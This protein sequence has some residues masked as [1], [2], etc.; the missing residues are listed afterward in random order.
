MTDPLFHPF[1]SSLEGISV[2]KAFTYPFF[3]TPHALVELASK[4][5]QNHLEANDLRHNFGLGNHEDLVE[6]GKMFGV[7]VVRNQD[8]HLGWLAA[9]SGKLHEEVEGYFVPPICDIHAAQ[10]FYKKGENELNAMSA[11]IQAKENNPERLK[12]I[13]KVN[14]RLADIKEHLRKGRADLKE[15]KKARQKY[16]ETVAKVMSESDFEK[17]KDRLAQESIQG[18]VAFKHRSKAWIEEQ[19]K[20]EATL[21]EYAREIE[22][23]KE[24][25]KAK[26]NQLQREIFD[27]YVFLNASGEEKVLSQCF[28]DFDLRHPPS[29]SG[30]CAAPKLLQYAYQKGL[31]PVCMG[32]FW[33]GSA[34]VK[35][36]RKHKYFY[37]S[38]ASRCRPIL[39]HMLQGLN[40]E[41][42][43]LLTFGKDKPMPVVY[44]DDDLVVVNKPAGLLSVPGVDI[45]DSALVRVK[46]MYPE[47][48]GAILLHRLDMSTSGLLMFTLNPKANKRMQ[49]Q[50]IKRQVNKTYIADVVGTLEAEEGII[51]LPLAPDYY[52]L[53]RQMVCHKTGKPS[54]TK[55]S[56]VARNKGTTRL[57]M[58]PVTGRTHQLR[59]HCAH[60]EGLGLPMVGDELYGVIGERLHLHAHKLEFQHPTT[61]E[62]ITITAPIPF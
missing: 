29:G 4:E 25:R 46:H 8:G 51:S 21:E 28:P 10:S 30:D 26:S 60:P 57:A 36:V 41:E 48:T 35:E 62:L 58:K 49:R 11:E 42:N 31:S 34:P 20:L 61:K 44:E 6:Q 47:A 40:V 5:L 1:E 19:E 22:A 54:E 52:D 3:Y 56:V 37:P 16:R 2:P 45:E 15:A 33:W 50:F 27:H 59:V 13:A 23:M 7:L 12:S 18:Q 17:V 14:E 38:C 24:V 39:G 9:Y 53:P 55:W 43:P 32:E